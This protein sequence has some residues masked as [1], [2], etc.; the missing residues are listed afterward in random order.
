MG[1]FAYLKSFFKDKDVASVTPT[2]KACV[3]HV[4]RPINFEEDI[5]IVEYGA[6]SGVFSRYLLQNM[7]SDSRLYLFETNEILFDKLKQITDPRV[8]LFNQSVE[9]VNR[10]LPSE[11][12]GKANYIISGIPFSFLD[13]DT[14]NS[15]LEQ[16]Y[17]LLGDRGKFLAY[18]TSGHLKETLLGKFGKGH[19]TTEWEWRNIPPMT[20]YEAEKGKTK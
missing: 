3:R 5:T 18:Q 6:G 17:R 12:I 8:S 2:S 13:E 1:T 20:V 14:K 15:I 10:L 9:Y 7:S 19:V 4:C 11:L 16:S